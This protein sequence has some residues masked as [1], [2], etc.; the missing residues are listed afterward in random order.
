[1]TRVLMVWLF[2]ATG[3]GFD[4]TAGQP[5]EPL[6]DIGEPGAERLPAEAA[7]AMPNRFRSQN[8]ALSTPV[9]VV[10]YNVQY[11]PDPEA[12]AATIMD[13]PD[14]RLASVILLQ[15]I[16]AYP[17]EGRSRS[18]KI[19]ERLGLAF[20]YVPARRVSGDG[21]HG[22]AILSAFPIGNVE[23]MFLPDAGKGHPRI[24]IQADIEL[25]GGALHVI[26]LHLDTKLNTRERIA[27]LRP[28][29]LDAPTQTLVAGDFNSCWVQWVGGKVPLLSSGA[30]TDQSIVVD[31][32]MRALQFDTPTSDSGPTERLHGVEQRLDSM[33]SR[34]LTV[35]Y[36]GVE[37]VGPS[38][39]W[40]MWM[41][42][43]LPRALEP[44]S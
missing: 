22:L 20:V 37:R 18:A 36:G 38:D 1:M 7:V 30:A 16:E 13:H 39:H 19:A 17:S 11:G 33:Y 27:H 10:T 3:C 26:N 25:P 44:G 2:A 43:M 40:P 35:R 23:R 41:D 9:R 12:L 15:E 8:P 5:W 21:T 6:A 34:G 28:A 42:V 29:V 4:L 24:A 14:L 31:S 32:Y